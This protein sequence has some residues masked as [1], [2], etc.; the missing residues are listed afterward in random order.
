MISVIICEKDIVQHASE[1]GASKLVGEF[2]PTERN[3]LVKDH[4]K[5]LGFTKISGK[6]ED[7]TWELET[8]NYQTPSLPM[9]FKYAL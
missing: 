5:K 9:S 3:I 2:S 8:S 1:E 4:Y 7:E 6:G